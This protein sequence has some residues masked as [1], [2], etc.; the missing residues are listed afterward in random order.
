MIVW[1]WGRGACGLMGQLTIGEAAL[2]RP[3]PPKHCPDSRL[4][5]TPSLSEKNAYLL[6]QELWPGSHPLLGV[7]GSAIWE[8]SPGDAVSALSLCLTPAHQYLPKRSS[9]SCLVPQFLPRLCKGTTLHNLAPMAGRAYTHRSPG[10]KTNEER[11]LK[12]L[13]PSGHSEKQQT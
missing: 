1:L 6:V 2:G 12:Q 8:Q 7:Y 11:V 13:G 3:L 10:T 5:H 4:K 9:Y